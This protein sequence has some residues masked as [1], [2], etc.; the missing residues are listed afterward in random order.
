MSDPELIYV[1]GSALRGTKNTRDLAFKTLREIT[2]PRRCDM[3]T[4]GDNVLA[5]LKELNSKIDQLAP[6]RRK[7]INA[8][9]ETS[10]PDTNMTAPFLSW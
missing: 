2:A 10:K 5:T 4:Y 3:K 1:L 8:L 9:I 6:L 7:F